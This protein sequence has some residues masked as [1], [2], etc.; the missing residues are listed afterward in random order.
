MMHTAKQYEQAMASMGKVQEKTRKIAR[1]VL[2]AADKSGHWSPL[3]WGLNPASKPEHSSG[4]AIDFMTYSDTLSG[5]YIAEYLWLHRKRLG[6]KW[7]IFKQRVRST[8]PGKGDNWR[9]MEDRGNSTANHF[10][11]VHCFFDNTPYV[12]P[13]ESNTNSPYY[14]VEEGD[15]L[16]RIAIRFNT[17]VSLLLVANPQIK[18][19]NFIKVG[20]K[21]SLHFKTTYVVKRGDNLTAIAKAYHTT[22]TDIMRLN[23]NIRDADLI[24]PGQVIR[25]P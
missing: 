25:V 7:V 21:I 13:V 10:D 18:D 8:T 14:T 11:H 24:Y 19:P 1:E 15:T 6:L 23:P 17:T 20:D 22:V 12:A 5:D 3:L 9:P 16:S 4:Y 2:E